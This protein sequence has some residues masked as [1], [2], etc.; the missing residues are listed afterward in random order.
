[1]DNGKATQSFEEQAEALAE[2][3]LMLYVMDGMKAKEDV[4]QLLMQFAS[5]AIRLH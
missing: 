1:M 3:I 5:Q 2:E 4:K